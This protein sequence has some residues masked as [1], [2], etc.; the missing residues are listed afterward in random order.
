MHLPF[1]NRDEERRR[2]RALLSRRRGGLAVL[3][4]RRRCGK[5]RLVQEVLPARRSVYYVGDDREAP[6][7][8]A[9]LAA[10]IG[11]RIPGFGV[12]SYPDWDS[13]LARWFREASPGMV[14]AIDEFPA[15][16]ASAAELPS[17]LQKHVDAHR[18]RGVHLVLSGSSQR[19]MQG[20]VFD[21]AAP[22]F[23][24]ADEVLRVSPLSCRWIGRALGIRDPVRAVEAYA[25]WGGVPRYW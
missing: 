19:M 8:R 16:V 6:L 22:L 25:V 2:L 5:S 11:R 23:G 24:R 4:G 15:L 12:V 3:F 1:L 13:L 10:E 18:A 21:R 20:L 9:S 17:L 14:L 7:Q